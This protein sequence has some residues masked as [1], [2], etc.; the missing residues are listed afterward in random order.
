VL[1]RGNSVPNGVIM[2]RSLTILV[3]LALAVLQPV[4][5]T[6]QTAPDAVNAVTGVWE[7]SNADRDRICAVTL[8][9]D[10]VQGG[11]R[12]E[13]DRGCAG[14]FPIMREVAAWSL[15]N[16]MLLL[17]DA[18]NR[19]VLQFSEVEHGMY[20]AERPG[21]GLY[22]MQT[23]A[24][25]GP[26]PRT[27]EQMMGEWA[28][29]RGENKT[30]CTLVLTNSAVPGQEGFALQV[31]QPCDPLVTR[32]NPGSWRMNLGELVVA[33]RGENTWRFEEDDPTTWRRVPEGADPLLLVRK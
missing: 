10:P 16:E 27:A 15:S 22:F 31:R 11:F 2:Q 3:L 26:A 7:I 20:E 1:R 8:K 19:T 29:V 14:A 9:A 4:P 6:A 21:E 28:V 12:L 32:F 13:L 5:S 30:V 23:L 24:A 18:R 17:L 25:A 33:G